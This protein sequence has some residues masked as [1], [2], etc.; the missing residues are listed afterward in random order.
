ME[1][2]GR[3]KI[4]K[5]SCDEIWGKNE[6]CHL[7]SRK[8]EIGALAKCLKRTRLLTPDDRIIKILLFQLGGVDPL[9]FS[10]NGT[11]I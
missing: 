8:H 4:R 7:L 11:K 2:E 5:S 9:A 1:H 10:L 6:G 3:S